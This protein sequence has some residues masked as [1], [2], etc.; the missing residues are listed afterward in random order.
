MISD[1]GED[2]HDNDDEYP[3]ACPGQEACWDNDQ[4]KL[5]PTATTSPTNQDQTS[6]SISTKVSNLGKI[7]DFWT[8]HLHL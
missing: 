3:R 1:D 2:G 7:Q 5:L 8:V 6:Q 4:I